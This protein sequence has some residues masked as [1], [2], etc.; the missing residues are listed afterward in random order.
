MSNMHAVVFVD[1]TN[2]VCKHIVKFCKMY[3]D[4]FKIVDIGMLQ[5]TPDW[6]VGVPTVVLT[7][8]SI[9]EALEAILAIR[10]KVFG[11]KRIPNRISLETASPVELLPLKQEKSNPTP[12]KMLSGDELKNEMKRRMKMYH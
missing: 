7:D 6:L 12:P 3:P 1:V 2:A 5:N 8:S 10:A 9:H 11:D 4:K